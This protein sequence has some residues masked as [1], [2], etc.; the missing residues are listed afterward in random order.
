MNIFLVRHGE[1]L[2]NVDVTV[3][4]TTADH[5]VGLSEAGKEQA[6]D[7]GRFLFMYF[8]ENNIDPKKTRLWLSPYRRTRETADALQAA[9]D[10]KL[11]DRKEDILLC[12]QQFGLFDGI[13]DED[14][15]KHYPDEA[16]HY[17]KCEDHE[18]RFWARM[19]LGESRFDVALRIRL[20]FGTIQ[21]DAEK[22]NIR[23]I[24]VVCHGVTLRAFVMSWLHLSPEWFEKEKNPK[25][26]W[27]RLISD[28]SDEG[29]IYQGLMEEKS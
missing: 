19:P 24:V 8:Q 4:R 18:G 23:N 29:Y 7:A 28:N 20:F 17:Q 11:R 12:E 6:L 26:C 2:A 15:A 16:A 13:R 5:A 27:I 14:L 22:K 10:G 25:N 21:R 9:F 1:S 3:Y